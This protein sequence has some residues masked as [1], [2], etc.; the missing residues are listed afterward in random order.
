LPAFFQEMACATYLRSAK[1]LAPTDNLLIP[2]FPDGK[3]VE[4]MKQFPQTPDFP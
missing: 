1:G 4:K 2:L 3:G